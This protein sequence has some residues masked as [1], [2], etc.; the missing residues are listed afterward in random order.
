[1]HTCHVIPLTGH[2]LPEEQALSDF[3]QHTFIMCVW[4]SF[5][6]TFHCC[7]C[8]CPLRHVQSCVVYLLFS[9]FFPSSTTDDDALW[10]VTKPILHESEFSF[11]HCF[12]FALTG[13]VLHCS[14]HCSAL[15]RV[16]D[17]SQARVSTHSRSPKCAVCAVFRTCCWWMHIQLANSAWAEQRRRRCLAITAPSLLLVVPLPVQQLLMQP[18]AGHRVLW[19]IFNSCTLDYGSSHLSALD[20]GRKLPF[21]LF[22]HC[23]HTLLHFPLHLCRQFVLVCSLTYYIFLLIGLAEEQKMMLAFLSI[24]ARVALFWRLPMVR[25]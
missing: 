4:V 3:F 5:D 2:S 12:L 14:A 10:S 16:N 9:F 17:K 8:F 7:V 21:I 23:E 13:N 22:F 11:F 6:C 18:N 19:F 25:S 15:E 20:C 24:Y 1:M